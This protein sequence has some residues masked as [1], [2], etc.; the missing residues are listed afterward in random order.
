MFASCPSQ[1]I[2]PL[3]PHTAEIEVRAVRPQAAATPTATAAADPLGESIAS[4]RHFDRTAVRR[5]PRI[6]RRTIWCKATIRGSSHWPAGRPARGPIRGMWPW[7]WRNSPTTTSPAGTIP[8]RFPPRSKWPRAARGLARSTRCC[9]A[10]LARARGIPARIAV[11]LVYTESTPG[12]AF[13]TWNEALD[14]RPMDSAGLRRAAKAASARPTQTG[15][16]EPRRRGGLQLLPACLAGDRPDQDRDRGRGVRARGPLTRRA[17]ARR[18]P[19][20]DSEARLRFR[21]LLCPAPT[22]PARI[23]ALPAT[24]ATRPVLHRG[25]FARI[26]RALAPSARRPRRN[27]CPLR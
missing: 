24:A 3:D 26:V 8:R 10:A 23:Q 7:H 25:S 1:H 22:T 14:R 4:R 13:H 5:P 21:A 16:F 6:A 2:T 9:L 18:M 27:D 12:F 11:G 20:F 19:P 17:Q 15:R